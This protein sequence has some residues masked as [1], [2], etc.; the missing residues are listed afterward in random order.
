M[1]TT[2]TKDRPVTMADLAREVLDEV[3]GDKSAAIAELE[4]RLASDKAL[5]R[6]LVASAIDTCVRVSVNLKTMAKRSRIAMAA[7]RE[8]AG[9]AGVQALAA[10][11]ANSLLDYPMSDGT[12]LRNANRDQIAVT[13]DN[14]A[15]RARTLSHRSRFLSAV[16]DLVPVQGVAGDVLD[17][18]TAQQLWEEADHDT[19]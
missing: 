13:R 4:H 11:M 16:L 8:G 15:T 17:E 2:L 7:Q 9:Q 3:G 14:A 18:A 6:A 12:P 5:R 10:G 19:V 1:P